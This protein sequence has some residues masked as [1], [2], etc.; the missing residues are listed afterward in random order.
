[1][2]SDEMRRR[3]YMGAQ[4]KLMTPSD[5]KLYIS[6]VAYISKTISIIT[7]KREAVRRKEMGS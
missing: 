5:L 7:L 4:L 2:A 6:R 1:M 3:H